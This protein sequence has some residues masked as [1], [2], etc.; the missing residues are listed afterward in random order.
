MRQKRLLNAFH[1]DLELIFVRGCLQVVL[2]V[3][4][5]V[6]RFDVTGEGAS[7]ITGI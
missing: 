3:N 1:R 2:I 5:F 6:L 4:R 7:V